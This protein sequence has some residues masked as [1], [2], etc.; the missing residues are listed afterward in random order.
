M[1]YQ[2]AYNFLDT[3][4]TYIGKNDWLLTIN[5]LTLKYQFQTPPCIHVMISHMPSLIS[6]VPLRKN[7]FCRALEFKIIINQSNHC[8]IGGLAQAHPNYT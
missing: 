4:H 8:N 6:Y 5:K 2:G 3:D 7:G 1:G